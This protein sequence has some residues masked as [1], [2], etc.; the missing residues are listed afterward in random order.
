MDAAFLPRDDFMNGRVNLLTPEVRANPYP[1]YAELRRA[2]VCQVDPGGLWAVTRYEDV[3]AVFKDPQRFSSEG[4]R[5]AWRPA[6]CADYPM[7]DSMIVMDPPRHGR[8]RALVNRAFNTAALARLEP[9][10]RRLAERVVAELPMGRSV[11]FIEAFTHRVPAGVVG[12][13]LGLPASMHSRLKPW[14]DHLG[15]FTGVAADDLPRQAQVRAVVDEVR[16][17]LEA[18][19]AERRRQPGQDMV[20]DLLEARVDG[21][22]LTET[23]LMGFLFLL[24]VAGLETTAHLL[25]HSVK[26]LRDEPALMARLR[27]EP[28]LVPRFLEEMLRHEPPVHGVMR[29][30]TEEVELGGT[31]LPKGARLVL[32]LCSANRDEAHF[33]EAD[34]FDLERG[35]PQNLP[36]G[37][38]IHFCL[39]APLARLEAR[40]ALEALLARCARLEPG[41]GPVRWNTSWVVRGPLS[42]PGVAHPA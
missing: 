3:M 25:G 8:L 4:L 13:L 22:A 24:L 27:A 26:R 32:L 17:H 10:I 36:F 29:L 30:T 16:R 20:S 31:R 9:S 2:P 6:W 33:P 12:E 18:V 42:L 14:L 37:H 1:V 28:A 23:E 40:L 41:E 39:G 5:Q 21:E 7:A 19:V 35:G 15:Q 34:R 38:G 11:D